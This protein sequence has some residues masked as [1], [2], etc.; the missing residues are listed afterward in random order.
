MWEQRVKNLKSHEKTP[1][2]AEGF[3]EHIGRGLYRLT[4]AGQLH[5]EHNGF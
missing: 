4:E 5:L 1:G 3:V 2:I